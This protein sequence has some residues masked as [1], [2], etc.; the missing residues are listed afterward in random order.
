MMAIT[1]SNSISVNAF[2]FMAFPFGIGWFSFWYWLVLGYAAF[3][4]FSV[5]RENPKN[6]GFLG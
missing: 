3:K 5:L 1:T 4:I 2:L 6:T